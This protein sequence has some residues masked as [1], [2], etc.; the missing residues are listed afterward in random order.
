MPIKP[1]NKK[2]Y[3]ANWKTEIR[4]KILERANNCCENC[5]VANK[6]L[7]IYRNNKLD[8][9]IEPSDF[10]YELHKHD[11]GKTW[12]T[13]E[14]GKLIR[15]RKALVVLTI[16]HLDHTPE[17]CNEDNLRAWCQRCHNKYDAK[18][19]AETRQRQKQEDK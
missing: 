12:T 15:Y 13:Y 14:N 18:H 19:R 6:S 7:L 9:I 4:P 1:E 11:A 3:P 8:D 10:V 16:A 17:N 5:G 2:R